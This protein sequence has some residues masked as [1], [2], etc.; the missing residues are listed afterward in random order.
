ME[1]VI[2]DIN[3]G[4]EKLEARLLASGQ[5]ALN[6]KGPLADITE[7]MFRIEEVVFNSNG[8]RGG[9]S[10]ARLK[11]DTVRKKKSAVILQDTGVLKRSVTEPGAEYQILDITNEGIAFGTERPFAAVQQSGSPARNIPARPFLRFLPTDISRWNLLILSHLM[12]PFVT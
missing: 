2:L 4:A 1:Y 6:L 12:E 3:G 11:D 9:G 8:R 10:W 5:K 7:D